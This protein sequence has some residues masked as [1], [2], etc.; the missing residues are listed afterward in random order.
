MRTAN[1]VLNE[2]SFAGVRG[3]ATGRTMTVQGAVNKIGLSLTW[4]YIQILILLA[5]LRGGRR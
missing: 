1:P 4:L 5:K 2:R 3:V